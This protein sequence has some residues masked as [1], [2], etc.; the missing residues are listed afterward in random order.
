MT[1]TF[2]IPRTLCL[3][4][5]VLA[6]SLATAGLSFAQTDNSKAK[7]YGMHMIALKPGVTGEQFER[8]FIEKVYPNWKVPGWEVSL[9]KGDRGDREGRYLVLVEIDSVERRD[10]D[11]PEH[12]TLS[13][14]FQQ[15]MEPLEEVFEEWGRLATVPGEST[16]YTDYYVVGK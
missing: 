8:F 15:H 14:E 3:L 12:G 5:S 11:A 13:E 7:V 4:V 10:R 6:I 16:I 1:S 2:Q 9:L